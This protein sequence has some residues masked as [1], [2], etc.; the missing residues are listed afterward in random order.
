M[1]KTG[2]GRQRGGTLEQENT[3]M[4]RRSVTHCTCEETTEH[5][6][7]PRHHTEPERDVMEDSWLRMN[8]QITSKS[9]VRALFSQQ[10]H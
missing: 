2:G 4:C 6:K 8:F 1:D 5:Q 7:E 9:T 3:T 10:Q